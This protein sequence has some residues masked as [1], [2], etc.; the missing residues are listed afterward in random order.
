MSQQNCEAS[1]MDALFNVSS[2]IAQ[3][4]DKT[5][6]EIKALL[7]CGDDHKALRLMRKHF[8]VAQ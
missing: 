2:E 1:I 7:E 6:R 4:R 3:E 8:G 5:E